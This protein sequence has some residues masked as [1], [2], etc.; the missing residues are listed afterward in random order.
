MVCAQPNEVKS[1]FLTLHQ[2]LASGKRGA[3][4]LHAGCAWEC[5]VL[6]FRVFIVFI[7]YYYLLFDKKI[8]VNIYIF[9]VW[10]CILNDKGIN[11]I[12]KCV[13]CLRYVYI[14]L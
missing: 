6:K 9:E 7:I 8:I 10:I 14:I 12:Y 2:S 4:S 5:R 1:P 13:L 11:I 3:Q